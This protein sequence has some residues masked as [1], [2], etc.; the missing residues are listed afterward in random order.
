MNV[1]NLHMKAPN[2][3][4]PSLSNDASNVHSEKQATIRSA[5]ARFIR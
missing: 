2:G 5:M 1:E 3:H 4:D